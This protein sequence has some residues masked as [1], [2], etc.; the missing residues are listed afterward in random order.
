MRHQGAEPGRLFVARG[1]APGEGADA[2][3]QDGDRHEKA[4]RGESVLG[5][6]PVVH[7]VQDEGP[8]ENG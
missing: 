5:G 4:E 3:G 2:Q 8:T 1:L 7:P 6:G